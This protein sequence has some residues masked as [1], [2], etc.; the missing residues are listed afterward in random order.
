MLL[1]VQVKPNAR[2][3]G[4][5]RWTEAGEVVLA[6]AAPPV[7]GK[8]NAE[9]TRFLARAL[10]LAKADVTIERGATARLKF[11]RLPDG[12]SLDALRPRGGEPPPASP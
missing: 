8:A 9:V 7:D 10:H 1:A 2:E 5:V 6:V 12:T 11:V 3:T 4:V